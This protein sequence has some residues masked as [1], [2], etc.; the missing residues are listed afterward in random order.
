MFGFISII[1]FALFRIVPDIFYSMPSHIF[2]NGKFQVQFYGILPLHLVSSFSDKVGR[3]MGVFTEPGL[4]QIPLNTALYFLLFFKDKLLLKQKQY[5]RYLVII[6][7][8]ILTCKATTAYVVSALII[9]FYIFDQHGSKKYQF[10]LSLCVLLLFLLIDYVL[11]KD[12]SLFYSVLVSKISYNGKIDLTHSTALYRLNTI[13]YV[14][15]SLHENI[16]GVGIDNFRSFLIN[17]ITGISIAGMS[18]ITAFAYY[19]IQIGLFY[20]YV[21]FIGF[22]NR[23]SIKQYVLI[24]FVTI[25][26][27][28]SQSDLFYPSLFILFYINYYDEGRIILYE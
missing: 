1:C 6:A 3:N 27:G 25:I 23:K 13:V 2:Y 8:A 14:F 24:V 7:F 12:N 10:F 21:L 9:C 18:L 28:L 16:W 22:K 5:Y 17:D 20:L 19:G 26:S 15:D 11:N 4:Y